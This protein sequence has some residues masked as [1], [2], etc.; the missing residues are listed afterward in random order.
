MC[1]V[2]RLVNHSTIGSKVTKK[3]KKDAEGAGPGSK[4][5]RWH[6][7]HHRTAAARIREVRVAPFGT[8]SYFPMV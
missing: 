1:K 4:A 5:A 3:K 2:H 8:V 6:A 7:P